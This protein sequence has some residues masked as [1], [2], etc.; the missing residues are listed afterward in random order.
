[1]MGLLLKGL[2]LTPSGMVPV[3][4]VGATTDLLRRK[5][6]AISEEVTGLSVVALAFSSEVHTNE[7]IMHVT[8]TREAVSNLLDKIAEH[9]SHEKEDKYHGLDT[10]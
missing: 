7:N 5:S 6:S 2:F 8:D 10:H 4:N 1:M 9:S 3:L